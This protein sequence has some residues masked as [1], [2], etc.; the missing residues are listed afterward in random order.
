MSNDSDRE[1]PARTRSWNRRRS[2]VATSLAASRRVTISTTVHATS[3]NASAD[4][5]SC[6]E[7]TVTKNS[8][9]AYRCKS[10]SE[11]GI[12]IA[13]ARSRPNTVARTT[14][15]RNEMLGR[16][17]QRPHPDQRRA[18]HRPD[19]GDGQ[20]EPQPPPF[21]WHDDRTRP[22][23]FEHA[24][25]S[26]LPAHPTGER[27]AWP[28]PFG[29]VDQT[30]ARSERQRSEGTSRCF[31]RPA[32]ARV[33]RPFV[34]LERSE[35]PTERPSAATAGRSAR[36][37]TALPPAAL[38]FVAVALAYALF[39]QMA[40]SLYGAANIG[41]SFFPAAGV[42]LGALVITPRRRWPVVLAAVATAEIT[43][44]L[45]NGLTLGSHRRVR[46]RQH[47]RA[48]RRRRGGRAVRE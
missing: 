46:P 35:R 28:R 43:I 39:A 10:T 21:G 24:S 31:E 22:D 2:A 17:S 15:S 6:S 32:R 4:H 26:P 19:D 48:A 42:S 12:A 5:R 33:G 41:V 1:S 23:P 16:D 3:P 18:Q 30:R 47:A 11:S 44:D 40:W 8:G 37:G 9:W 7:R 27:E 25:R 34:R 13:A 29:T 20:A 45:W 36:A 38:T 14:E